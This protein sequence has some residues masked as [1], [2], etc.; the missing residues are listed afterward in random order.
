MIDPEII[1]RLAADQ[2]SLRA[3]VGLAK[4]AKWSALGSGADVALIWGEC[5]GSGARPYRVTA[6][7]RDM[8]NKCTCPS[9]KFPCK[10][11]I[12]LLCLKAEDR[13][14]FPPADVPDW[15]SDWLSR[16][17]PKATPPVRTGPAPD[18][19]AARATQEPE[20]ADPKAEARRI[21]TAA[22]REAE[23]TQGVRDALDVLDQWIGDQLRL[24]L[25]TFMGDLM[26]RCRQVAARLVDGKAVALARRVDEMPARILALPAGE[27]MR[28]AVIELGRLVQITCAFR[29]APDQPE[30]RRLVCTAESRESVLAHPDTVH[31]N[32]EWEVL[33]EQQQAQRDRLVAHVVWLLNLGTDGP[34][35]ALLLDFSHGATR[36]GAQ[37]RPGE[38]FRGTVAF[39]PAR[40]PLRGILLGREPMPDGARAEW[41][42][43]GQ[44]PLEAI[45]QTLLAEPWRLEVP[46]M[47]PEGRLMRDGAGQHWWRATD[48]TLALPVISDVKGAWCGTDLTCA[49]A[50][51][52]DHRLELLAAQSAWGRL[53][54]G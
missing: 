26:T 25:A 4:P 46:L 2:A 8:G 30:I 42:P 40:I 31:L 37:F 1:E 18:L 21:A 34:R 9:R 51:W 19:Q 47:L 10:H 54:H 22:K 5:A 14:P 7:L 12:G 44:P 45:N 28:V 20:A 6:D 39:Y 11:V 33:A 35:F 36:R 50:I 27:R 43:C 23:T 24:G 29:A 38:R 16:R 32:T 48:G 3:G 17:R 41:P 52:S 15:V 49:V 53:G 13:A